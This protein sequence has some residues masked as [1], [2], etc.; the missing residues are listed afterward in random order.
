MPETISLRR[1]LCLLLA[2]CSLLLAPCS[3]SASEPASLAPGL[4]YLHLSSA[5]GSE[6]APHSATPAAGALVL[7]LR[8]VVAGEESAAALQSALAGRT[9]ATPLFI[10][11][12]PATPP[13][14]AQA[15]TQSSGPVVT[16]GIAGSLPAPKVVV[17]TDA[18]TDRQAYDALEAG[19]PVEALISGKIEKERFD[20]A[21]LMKE[22]KNG[23]PD[24][25]P[26]PAPDPT[27][28]K[29][30]AVPEK[31]LPLVDR[32][33]QRAVHLHQALLALRR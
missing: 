23:N 3:L 12:S 13:A 30:P 9:G 7:D 17:K 16:L 29:S 22:F 2:F 33:L 25:E 14:L 26:P 28:P 32:V 27:A 8:Y 24:A 31:T 18:A 4:S 1:F 10:L 21:T 19:T 6:K 5:A 20:E 15:I 11:V